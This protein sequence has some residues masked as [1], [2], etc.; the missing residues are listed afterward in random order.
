MNLLVSAYL[1]LAEFQA[2]R[3]MAMAMKDWII[4]TNKF[5]D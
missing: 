3:Q 5:L 4:R 2:R 1:D